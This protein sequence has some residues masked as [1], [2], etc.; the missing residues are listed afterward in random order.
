MLLTLSLTILIT[1]V[2]SLDEI[3][4]SSDH[5]YTDEIFETEYF[6]Q[7]LRAP[8]WT[9]SCI[10]NVCIRKEAQDAE[11]VSSLDVCWLTCGTHGPVWPYPKKHR[12]GSDSI[13][14]LPGNF[15]LLE[16]SAESNAVKQLV[17]Q[18]FNLKRDYLKNYLGVTNQSS[19]YSFFWPFS[20][21][22][23]SNEFESNRVQITIRVALTDEMLTLVTDESYEI[24]IEEE[25]QSAGQLQVT[26]SGKTFFG[27]R[28]GIETLS[29]VI[30]FE[31]E[32]G[33]F[34]IVRN[35]YAMDKPAY[36]YR[37]ILIDSAR[38]FIPLRI[39]KRVIDAM[40]YNKLNMLHLHL[41]DSNAFT[42]HSKSV[43]QMTQYGALSEN[44]IY[45]PHEM[46]DLVKYARIR[47][48]KLVP[49]L[50]AP[51][52]A[53]NGW[54][55]GSKYGLGKLAFYVNAYD[56]SWPSTCGQPPC[57]LLNP[58]NIN[59]YDILERIYGD[60]LDVF[61]DDLFH[62]GGDEVNTHS[63]LRQP[64]MK[65]W[66]H[67]RD[68]LDLWK[69]FQTEAL[70][71]LKKV[72]QNATAILWTSKLTESEAS[73][74]YLDT[75]DYIIQVWDSSTSTQIQTL[76]N[77]GFSLIMSFVDT[78]YLDWG[79]GSW[80]GNQHVWPFHMW[81]KLYDAKLNVGHSRNPANLGRSS[82]NQVLGA[83]APLWGEKVGPEELE[84]KLW[85]RAAAL[86]ENLWSNPTSRGDEVYTRLNYHNHRL[87][88]R[89]IPTSQLQP[90][91][92]LHYNGHCH[93]PQDT[94]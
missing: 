32:C 89:G 60:M 85:P 44:H 92:C 23:S 78:L 41:S 22:S 24:R 29:Q 9:Y 79:E 34:Q 80:L 87:Q 90:E 69:Y 58:L 13:K 73:K 18:A 11:A 39:I 93:N 72:N 2:L 37:G 33:C 38:N 48:V 88:Q 10:N 43:P 66:L 51:S 53:G 26:I 82:Q 74:K 1:K 46:A 36:P 27:V 55:F 25:A 4:A 6:K 77:K 17:E 7:K 21:S 35:Y 5:N 67:A 12:R 47:G 81:Q 64:E 54:Q 65:K 91:S 31:K 57:G 19:S 40:S 30:A 94:I 52:H 61:D 84:S 8:R 14:F 45:Y 28:H 16:V 20:S 83:E 42:F 71:R 68:A 75:N 50:D 63:W 3:S 56:N 59:T 86:A 76:L 70:K 62:M 15:Q 49:E